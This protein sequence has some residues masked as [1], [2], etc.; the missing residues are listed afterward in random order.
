ME[1]L[2]EQFQFLQKQMEKKFH[3]AYT[4]MS[5]FLQLQ[6]SLYIAFDKSSRSSLSGTPKKQTAVTN[7]FQKNSNKKLIMT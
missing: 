4:H 2:Y 1:A 5:D 7:F 3:L 6:T